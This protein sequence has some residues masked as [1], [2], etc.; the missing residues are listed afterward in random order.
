[1]VFIFTLISY[2]F[3]I[4]TAACEALEVGYTPTITFVIAQ[5]RHHAIFFP[6]DKRDADRTGNCLP[7]TVVESNI[8]HPFEFDFC[9]LIYKSLIC[10]GIF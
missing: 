9:K 2:S 6:F 5:K 8:T 7:G 10:L 1:M 3:Y 4:K